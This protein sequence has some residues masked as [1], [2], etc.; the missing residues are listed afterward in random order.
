MKPLYEI[1]QEMRE[2]NDLVNSGELTQE[3]IADTMDGMDYD[4]DVKVEAALKVR[5]HSVNHVD[6]IDNEIKRLQRLKAVSENNAQ[7]I[8]DNIKENMLLLKKDK[9][10]LGLFEV[11]LRKASKKLGVINEKHIPDKYWTIVPETKQLN[12]ALLL[13]ETKVH[14]ENGQK[15]F[16]ELVDSERALIIK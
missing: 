4:F 5:Q 12:K 9:L 13:N 3:D 2:L 1:T 8:A 10:N 7:R 6:N 11:T 15:P 14:I 16:V